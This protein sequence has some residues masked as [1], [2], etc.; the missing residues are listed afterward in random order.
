MNFQETK[1]FIFF[2]IFCQKT[3]T[4][5]D[6]NFNFHT[7]TISKTVSK[8]EKDKPINQH[9]IRHTFATRCIENG[10]DYISLRDMLDHS[11]IKITLDTYCDVIGEYRDKQFDL[12]EKI[13]SIIM[14]TDTKNENTPM[15]FAVDLQ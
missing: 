4:L 5:N 8:G 12:V 6:V 7:I 2:Q 13:N 3:L 10:I 14:Q 9:M 11:D 1:D 15:K